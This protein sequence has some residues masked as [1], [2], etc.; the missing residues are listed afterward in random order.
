MKADFATERLLARQL[1]LSGYGLAENSSI[2][3]HSQR[4]CHNLKEFQSQQRAMIWRM[5]AFGFRC[6]LEPSDR[7][8]LRDKQFI[9]RWKQ[10]DPNSPVLKLRV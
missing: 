3:S 2:A 1:R 7:K 6:I 10:S 8:N 9:N 5:P 4:S